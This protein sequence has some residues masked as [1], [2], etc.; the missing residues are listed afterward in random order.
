MNVRPKKLRER[1]RRRKEKRWEGVPDDLSH[2]ERFNLWL[3]G[4]ALGGT[5][6]IAWRA[7]K[8]GLIR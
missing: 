3:L 2:K 6:A 8:E 7:M 1:L 4:R 5:P